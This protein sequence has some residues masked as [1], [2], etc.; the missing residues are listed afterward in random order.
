MKENLVT[1]FDH[2]P[3][4]EIFA[5][6]RVKRPLVKRAASWLFTLFQAAGT[7]ATTPAWRDYGEIR[8]VR[9]GEVVRTV[10]NPIATSDDF[11]REA[12]LDL[13]AMNAKQFASK[14]GI[15]AD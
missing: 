3:A 5:L 1:D 6:D 7:E 10:H 8:D 2:S 14:W 12:T 11:V 9:S 15:G 4:G 13:E